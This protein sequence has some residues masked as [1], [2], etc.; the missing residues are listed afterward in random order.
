MHIL[1]VF[2]LNIYFP[3]F[4]QKV[5]EQ[6]LCKH[7]SICGDALIS[8]SACHGESRDDQ[9]PAHHPQSAVQ[10]ANQCHPG[11]R[12]SQ[13]HQARIHEVLHLYRAN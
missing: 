12:G 1:N 11:R 10:G 8:E 5:C 9:V 3:H 7:V 13:R 2:F 4:T 6:I